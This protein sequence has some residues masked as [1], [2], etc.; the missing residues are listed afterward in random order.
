MLSSVFSAV[1]GS[2]SDW[3]W[4]NRASHSGWRDMLHRCWYLGLTSF[5]GPAVHFQIVCT[6]CPPAHRDLRCFFALSKSI[7]SFSWDLQ[8]LVLFLTCTIVSSDD[9]LWKNINGSMSRWCVLLALCAK[10][11]EMA[12]GVRRYHDQFLMVVVTCAVPR[13][14]RPLSGAPRSGKHQD[15]LLY[16]RHPRGPSAGNSVILYLEA[17]I[18]PAIPRHIGET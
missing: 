9:C 3:K 10:S 15:D 12:E 5:G 6:F 13:A 16:Q 8:L 7:H 4:Q 11:Q 14:L 17:S 1:K 2:M 18:Q